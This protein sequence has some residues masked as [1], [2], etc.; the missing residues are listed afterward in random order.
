MKFSI[1]LV[2]LFFSTLMLSQQ[3]EMKYFSLDVDYFYGSI[4]EHNR[5][6]SHLITGHPT[7]LIVSYNR[8][9]YGFS[10]WEGRY[11][12]PDW[13]FT[14]TYQDMKN[15]FL[16]ENYAVYGHY[17]FYFLKR[18]L[19]FGMGQGIAYNTNP[20]DPETNYQNNAYGSRFLSS[21]YLRFNYVKE[22]LFKG[23]G[24]HAGLGV[25]HYSNANLKAPNTSTN[26]L[27]LMQVLVIYLMSKV[28]LNIYQ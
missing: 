26:T 5:D 19:V 17:N 16:G 22:N 11:N 4:I 27:F 14:F 8:K 1:Q 13:G 23:L 21:T 12:Y 15:Q 2:L 9:T 6:I 28:I 10:E 24:V 3:N 25:I 7:G 18:S 20:Y